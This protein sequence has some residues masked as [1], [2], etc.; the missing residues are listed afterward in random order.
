MVAAQYADLVRFFA[1]S[2]M[3]E[4]LGF[5]DRTQLERAMLSIPGR[6]NEAGW[7]PN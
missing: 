6:L 3:I 7:S 2:S 5:L 1:E 4:R